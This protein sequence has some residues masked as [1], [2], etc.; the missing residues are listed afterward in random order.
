MVTFKKLNPLV[1]TYC[2]TSTERI[3][4][5]P[6][7]S[8]GYI[9]VDSYC[10]DTSNSNSNERDDSPPVAV[11][12]KYYNKDYTMNSYEY[13]VH[14]SRKVLQLD[15]YCQ[16]TISFLLCKELVERMKEHDKQ[17]KKDSPVKFYS[18]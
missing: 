7:L 1:I 10:Q 11:L 2:Y 4:I 13:V 3:L 16:S 8:C 17:L 14:F 9:L 6:C 18:K 5:R 15:K 12:T